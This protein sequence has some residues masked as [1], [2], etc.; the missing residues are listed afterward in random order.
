MTRNSN[1]KILICTFFMIILGALLL[2]NV[3]FM[4]LKGIHWGSGINLNNYNGISYVE[5]EK[6]LASRGRIYDA[7]GY[8]LAQDYDAW[9]IVAY[10]S[11][12][13][14]GNNEGVYYVDDKEKTARVL[15][16]ILGADYQELYDL[17]S[18]DSFMTYLGSKARGISTE[19]KN[20]IEALNLNG[21]EFE[22]VKTRDYP[23]S[24]YASHLIGFADYTYVEDGGNDQLMG[25]TGVEAALDDYLTET[26][27]VQ[28]YYRDTKG[29]V[30]TGQQTSYTG[31]KNGDD[32]Y[33]T[34]NHRLQLALQEAL[35][36][37]MAAGT[38]TQLAWG[39]V[40]EAK[41]GRIVAYDNYPTYNQNTLDIDDYIDYN[42]MS[43]YEPGSVMKPFTYAIALDNGLNP[44]DT[45]NT[46]LFLLG[47]DDDG[48]IVR[49][50]GY[51]DPRFITTIR[52]YANGS[53]GDRDFWFGFAASVNTGIATL[54]EKYISKS[55]YRQYMEDFQ[56]YKT[57]DIF[58]I[59]NEVEGVQLM[60][61]TTEYVTSGY[62]QGSLYTALQIVQGYTAFCNEGKLIKPYIVD[63][64]VDGATGEIKYQ[65]K[66][67]VAG[68]PIKPETAKTILQMMDHTAN[69]T[70]DTVYWGG[71]H[72]HLDEVKVGVK[73]GTAE[74]PENG[75][76]GYRTIHCA[77]VV[78]PVDD[79]E[80]IMYVCYE[81]YDNYSTKNY[82]IMVNLEKTIALEYRMIS[83]TSQ[84]TNKNTGRTVYENAMPQ[85][86]NH[87]TEY[88]RNKFADIDVDIVTIGTGNTVLGQYPQ[89]GS[90]LVSGQKV[91]LLMN[92]GGYTMPDMRGWSRKEVTAFWELT[93]IEIVMDGSGYVVTQ[94]VPAG[95]SINNMTEIQVKLE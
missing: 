58:G 32:V 70:Q 20:Q 8:V 79:P 86:V 2:F 27:G 63:K 15:S 80:I 30:I 43:A 62:G 78:M 64:I 55:T 9:D 69:Y 92:A 28:S 90:T 37:S 4:D 81:D 68:Q 25:K 88:A 59:P 76:Y 13:R 6:I 45:F 5:D 54:F 34:I 22:R 42:A 11:P 94:N 85:L 44:Y 38:N 3:L 1:F 18:R 21:I 67:E 39:I 48:K 17:L 82:D 73:T 95:E 57:I 46:R 71:R 19:V 61:Y 12:D 52:N 31:A 65:G 26:Q 66:T 16:E 41:T 91:L 29:N 36:K 84:G 14:P 56:F 10:I 77:V 93:G 53:F 83:G 33:L 7:D 49:C 24:P 89:S 75:K 51:G 47:E 74:V 40:M 72:Y 35:V 23:Y 60:N 50:W 87:T